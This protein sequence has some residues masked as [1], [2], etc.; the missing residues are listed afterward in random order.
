LSLR[1]IWQTVDARIGLL[2]DTFGRNYAEWIARVVH[3]INERPVVINSDPWSMSR[4]T[5]FEHDLHVQ[6]DRPALS[7]QFTALCQRV[8]E[9]LVK[10]G[11]VC[12]TV[13]IKLRFA[14]S[15]T[16]TPDVTLPAA[17]ADATVI[18]RAATECL[19]RVVL[20]R[21][22]RLLGVRASALEKP[23]LCVCR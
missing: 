19:R 5:T 9:D 23:R 21:H 13:G 15:R 11:Y 4:E 8:S 6:Q 16:V 18:R 17:T 12:R 22:L 14:D 20:D 2:Q 10:K 3:G 1:L 7:L